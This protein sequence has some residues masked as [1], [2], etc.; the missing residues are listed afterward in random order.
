MVE[1]YLSKRGKRALIKSTL[2][3]ISTCSLSLLR[4]PASITSSKSIKEN[5]FGMRQIGQRSSIFCGGR[6]IT[7]PKKWGD[8]D[9]KV[10]LVFNKALLSKWLWRSGVKVQAFWGEVI[11]DKYGVMEG[12][13]R[14]RDVIMPFG[15]WVESLF[16]GYTHGASTI[17]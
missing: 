16:F 1:S 4:A 11:V 14:T 9:I 2:S 15:R 10:L 13:G 7:S 6:F 3:N 8:L 5:I 12:R 17:F